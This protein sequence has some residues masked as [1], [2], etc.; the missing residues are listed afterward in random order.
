MADK[1]RK[2]KALDEETEDGI[3]DLR[4][5]KKL[6]HSLF[7]NEQIPPTSHSASA[8][9]SSSQQA[10]PDSLLDDVIEVKELKSTEV[11]GTI[12]DL[13]MKFVHQ[14]LQDGS[15]DHFA[16]RSLSLFSSHC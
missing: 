13:V 7:P 14:I 10:H 16:L 3:A 4:E 8:L 11:I 15:C 9:A 5:I 2:L 6:S 1:K 12:E